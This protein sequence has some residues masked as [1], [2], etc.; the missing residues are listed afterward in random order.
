MKKD[1]SLLRIWKNAIREDTIMVSI[2]TVNNEIGAVQD[3][4]AIGRCIKAKNPK[5]LF[6]TDAIQAY[7]KMELRPKRDMVDLLSVSGHKLHGPKGI[8]FL[9]VDEK[10]KLSPLMLGGGHQNGLR[11]GTLNIP[12]L[13]DWDLRQSLATAILKKSRKCSIIEGFLY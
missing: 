10:V 11:S 9:Y 1:I 6:H 4:A 12:V 13:Q 8:G 3:I 2:M 5:T 7:G